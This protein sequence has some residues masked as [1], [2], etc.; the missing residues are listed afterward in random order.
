[1][2]LSDFK[3]M[4]SSFNLQIKKDSLKL[5]LSDLKMLLGSNFQTKNDA[6]KLQLSDLKMLLGSNFQTVPILGFD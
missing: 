5:Q 3:K 4:L 1:L 2:Q 6:L